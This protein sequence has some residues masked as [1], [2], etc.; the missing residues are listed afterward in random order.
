MSGSPPSIDPAEQE[1]LPVTDGVEVSR[2]G[3]MWTLSLD[4]ERTKQL[5]AVLKAGSPAAV[6]LGPVAVASLLAGAGY[7]NMTNDLGGKNGVDLIGAVNA[8]GFICTPRFSGILDDADML[9]KLGVSGRTIMDLI[10]RAASMSA[11][12]AQALQIPVV[13]TPSP[14]QTRSVASM[15]FW[16]NTSPRGS[17]RPRPRRWPTP[18]PAGCLWP[19]RRTRLPGISSSV[20]NEVNIACWG[21]GMPR[22][23]PVFSIRAPNA[24][25]LQFQHLLGERSPFQPEL[26]VDESN[27]RCCGSAGVPTPPV[28][29]AVTG[30][31]GELPPE[32]GSRLGVLP[33]LCVEV[34]PAIAH[35]YRPTH[36]NRMEPVEETSGR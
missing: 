26:R 12:L 10:V 25:T 36:Q 4:N 13:A 14:P 28:G 2:N 1:G 23:P 24:S 19:L 3:P 16:T 32:F 34:E 31:D 15:K 6:P 22:I 18:S 20:D 30:C 8:T 27:A 29:A 33:L 17:S 9:A 7:I 5:A 35:R 21:S 11:P